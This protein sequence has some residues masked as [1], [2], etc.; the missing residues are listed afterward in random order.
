M[1]KAIF[2][3]NCMISFFC[4]ATLLLMLSIPLTS[5]GD[6]ELPWCD[7]NPDC[8]E[9]RVNVAANII[10]ITSLEKTDHAVVVHTKQYYPAVS[11]GGTE[12]FVN[13]GDDGAADCQITR[14]W[15]RMDSNGN[16]DISFQL[17]DLKSC[18]DYLTKDYEFNI[19]RIEGVKTDETPF[20]GESYMYIVGKQG[21]DKS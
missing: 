9:I 11:L 7:D 3:K 10:N 6:D 19:L 16:L 15:Q 14:L 5:L 1:N 12:I 13:N 18:E 2:K 21:P 8:Y 4:I 17:D 20:W